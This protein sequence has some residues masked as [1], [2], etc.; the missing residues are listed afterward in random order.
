MRNW[1][2]LIALNAVLFRAVAGEMVQKMI[3][4]A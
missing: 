1:A 2:S 3:V 4:E